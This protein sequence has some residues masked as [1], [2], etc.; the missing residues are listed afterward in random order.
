MAFV[1]KFGTIA[2]LMQGQWSMF[3]REQC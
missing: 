1:G 3:A 2:A